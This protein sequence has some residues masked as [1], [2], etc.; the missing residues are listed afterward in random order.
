[1]GVNAAVNRNM[2][3]T[4]PRQGFKIAFPVSTPAMFSAT[5]NTGN[6]KANPKIN[7]MRTTKSRYSS[8]LIKLSRDVGVNPSNTL[9]AS[10]RM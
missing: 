9:I 10:G 4:L 5:K 3:N 2:P 1:M 8:N 6:S 7:I